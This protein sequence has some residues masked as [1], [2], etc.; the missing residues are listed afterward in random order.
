M[1][2]DETITG[3][4][5]PSDNRYYED[6]RV[7]EVYECGAFSIDENEIIAFATHYDPQPM[8]TDPSVSGGVVASGWH[9]ACLTMRLIADN[10]LS[11][12]ASLPSPGVE[13]IAWTHPI[14]PDEQINVVAKI[15]AMR[16]SLS[17]PDRGILTSTFIARNSEGTDVMTFRASNFVRRRDA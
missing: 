2:G 8:H 16:V 1:T 4:L 14:H 5:P 13:A 11:R 10:F 12:V 7:G 3:Y 6:Y 17:K 9:T 15:E